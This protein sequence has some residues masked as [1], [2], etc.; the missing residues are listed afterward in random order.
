MGQISSHHGRAPNHRYLDMGS[1]YLESCASLSQQPR[2][3]PLVM[4]AICF[5]LEWLGGCTHQGAWWQQPIRSAFCRRLNV[6]FGGFEG[7]SLSRRGAPAPPSPCTCN[8][9][10]PLSNRAFLRGGRETKSERQRKDKGATSLAI[11]LVWAPC[12][13]ASLP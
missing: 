9:L 2:F 6:N 8:H 1:W 13:P 4:K 5:A 11:L 10:V 7:P 12:L 3:G